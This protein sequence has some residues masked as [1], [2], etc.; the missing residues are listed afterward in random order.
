L[1]VFLHAEAKL[2]LKFGIGQWLMATLS[3]GARFT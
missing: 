2:L 1:P 3:V